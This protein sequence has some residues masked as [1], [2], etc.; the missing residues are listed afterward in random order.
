MAPI[1]ITPRPA[2][3]PLFN[4]R[5]SASHAN[6]RH[7]GPP[8]ESSSRRTIVALNTMNSTNPCSARPIHGECR[9]PQPATTT[10]QPRRRPGRAANRS[11]RRTPFSP[12]PPTSW[13]LPDR[14]C[15]RPVVI[16][17][18]R[19]A[20]MDE[21]NTAL[22]QRPAPS[23]N[24]LPARFPL[25][26]PRD[27][28]RIISASRGRVEQQRQT[29]AVLRVRSSPGVGESGERRP[30]QDQ[31]ASSTVQRGRS[32]RRRTRAEDAKPTCHLLGR[33]P[34]GPSGRPLGRVDVA[35]RHVLSLEVR[36]E[37]SRRGVS[38]S[39]TLVPRPEAAAQLCAAAC[40]GR[41]PVRQ[42]SSRAPGPPPQR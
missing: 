5:R 20:Q 14:V 35:L 7:A 36:R 1:S 4:H 16:V 25:A 22:G 33:P 23:A 32:T 28:S 27:R 40:W 24:S 31:A 12:K 17:M 19:H 38:G 3:P 41:T 42:A 13:A 34:V 15:V 11:G 39:A 10:T 26:N 37:R 8:D 9:A 6:S 29:D 18:K 21:V 2:A 30:G